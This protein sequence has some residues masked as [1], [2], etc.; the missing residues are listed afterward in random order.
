MRRANSVHESDEFFGL[1]RRFAFSYKKVV[2]QNA[3]FSTNDS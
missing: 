1:K 2:L 3:L